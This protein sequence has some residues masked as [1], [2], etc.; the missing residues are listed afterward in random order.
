MTQQID[1]LE[2]QLRQVSTEKQFWFDQAEANGNRCLHLEQA[3]YKASAE[4]EAAAAEITRLTPTPEANEV[5]A[6]VEAA[7]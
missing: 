1:I 7:E 5:E 6:T 4:L 2:R 3:L